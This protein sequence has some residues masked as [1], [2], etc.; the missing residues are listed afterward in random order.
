MIQDR[1]RR[2]RPIDERF[3]DGIDREIR[4]RIHTKKL[5]RSPDER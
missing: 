1:M 4:E 5:R 3:V 2:S